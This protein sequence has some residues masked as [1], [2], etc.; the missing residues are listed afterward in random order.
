MA[1]YASTY[2]ATT[3]ARKT[4]RIAPGSFKMHTNLNPA[5]VYA[6]GYATQYLTSASTKGGKALP[7]DVP[8][9]AVV[10][11]AL[12]AY[13][14]HLDSLDTVEARTTEF[15]TLERMAYTSAP[16]LE[17]Q[18]RIEGALKAAREGVSELPKLFQ[19]LMTGT[20]QAERIAR[21]EA[22]E[23]RLEELLP[24]RYRKAAASHQEAAK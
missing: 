5:A 6:L 21:M 8:A 24:Q 3:K 4:L 18:D 11:R 9:T 22:R 1:R 23:A 19:D 15:E 10:R 20:T 17:E 13:V 12:A 14:E 7:L 2:T 16:S